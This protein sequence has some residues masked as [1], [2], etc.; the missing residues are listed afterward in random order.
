MDSRTSLLKEVLFNISCVINQPN[1][2]RRLVNPA[3]IPIPEL[4]LKVH[5]TNKSE[6]PAIKGIR[7]NG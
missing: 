6:M 1:D 4:M 2:V 7:V 3:K 5:K